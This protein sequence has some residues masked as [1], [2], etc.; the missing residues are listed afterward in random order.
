MRVSIQ[1]EKIGMA[2]K[3]F[4]GLAELKLNILKSKLKVWARS[5]HISEV[6]KKEEWQS[7]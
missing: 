4:L 5:H 3:P 1:L 2:L 7:G 6:R